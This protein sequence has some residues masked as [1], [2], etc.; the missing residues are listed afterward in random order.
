MCVSAMAAV[1]SALLA[2]A[3]K[4]QDAASKRKVEL[5]QAEQNIKQAQIAERNAAYERQE[6]IDEARRQKL[7]AIQ[8]MGVIKTNLASGNIYSS[9][10]TA[11]N[12]AD[13]E[14][15]SG[16]MEALKLIDSSEK[17][18]QVYFDSA[19]NYYARAS[20][21]KFRSKQV[22]LN[23]GLSMMSSFA[24]TAAGMADNNNGK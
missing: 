20:L 11:L 3:V 14:K 13:D 9:S 22:M 21:N 19:Q 16:E 8:N 12:L 4:I 24:S 6:G 17:R 10:E 1:G 2:S 23:T 18:A 7:K 15:F 5:F